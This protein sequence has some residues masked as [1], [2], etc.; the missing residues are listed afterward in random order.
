MST[1]TD[2][3]RGNKKPHLFQNQAY[4]SEVIQSQ[5]NTRVYH[6]LTCIENSFIFLK[7]GEAFL[8]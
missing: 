2:I 4:V 1:R 3:I 8:L 5:F 6:F 7:Y